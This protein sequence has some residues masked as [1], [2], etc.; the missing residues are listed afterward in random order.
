MHKNDNQEVIQR[1]EY[2]A[3][4]RYLQGVPARDMNG[5][6]WNLLPVDLRKFAL[7]LGMYKIVVQESKK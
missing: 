6:E 1:V 3:K 5:T 2:V 7:D 4:N